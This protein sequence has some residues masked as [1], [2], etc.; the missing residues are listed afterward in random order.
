[1]KSTYF[2]LIYLSIIAFLGY[3][4]WSSVQAFKAFEHLDKQLGVDASVMKNSEASIW[5]SIEKNCRAYPSPVN[6]AFQ[7]KSEIALTMGNQVILSI[8][9]NR[10]SLNLDTINQSN[11]K[12]ISPNNS[13]FS[14]NK[15]DEIKTELMRFHDKLIQLPDTEDRKS[16]EDNLLTIKAIKDE[17]YWNGLKHLP[18]NGISAEL[19]ALNS[20]IQSD[21]IVMLNYFNS[22]IG[23]YESIVC[24]PTF[25][26]AI[27]P[28]N[29]ALIEGETFEADIYLAKYES[30][31]R[32]NL[33]IKVN[34]EPLEIKEGVAHFKSKNQTIGT[35]SIKAEA[36]IM[37]PLT[38][39]M[40]S[41]PCYFEYQVLPKCSRDCQ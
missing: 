23:G 25:R 18:L 24:G 38:G 36:L 15:I 14:S 13:F 34:G 20:Q 5:Q 28:K 16:I 19:S 33:I 9:K 39:L 4:Y 6:L 1:M 30:V 22:K 40:N 10:K 8:E 2:H 26:T 31:P 37:N 7:G 3:N 41:I 29:A 12:G 21:K 27:A 35:R 17:K 11:F 32:N